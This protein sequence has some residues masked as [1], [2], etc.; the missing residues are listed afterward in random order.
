[1]IL[2]TWAE[3]NESQPPSVDDIKGWADEHGMTFPVL[4]DPSWA[5]NNRFE[6]DGGIP[7]Q[8]LVGKGA[9][10]IKVDGGEVTEAEIEA[11]LAE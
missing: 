3:N 6:K 11:A 9:E 4:A 10:L 2:S 5:I 1:M 7:T 8:I